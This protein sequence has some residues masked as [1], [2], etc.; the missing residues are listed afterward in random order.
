MATDPDKIV[1][2]NAW[3]ALK[4]LEELQ[5]FLGTGGY[6]QQYVA[7]LAKALTVLTGKGV[8]WPWSSEAETAFQHLKTGLSTEPVLE[9]PDP[10]TQDILDIDASKVGISAVLSQ[11]Q[12]GK[13]MVIT[14]FTKTVAPPEKNYCGNG[15]EL[16][17]TVK[18]VNNFRPYLY[19][20]IL[21]LHKCS[22]LT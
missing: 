2:I 13:K 16:L 4:N 10:T 19:G 5:A 3:V 21:L 7:G 22:C 1:A 11:E 9:Y 12:E 20:Q 14:Y 17:L 6:Y 8:S 15:R 18:A